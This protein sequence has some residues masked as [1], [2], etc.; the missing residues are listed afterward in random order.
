MLGICGKMRLLT[1]RLSGCRLIA[2]LAFSW[3][4]EKNGAKVLLVKAAKLLDQQGLDE[5]ASG[6]SGACN[7][8]CLDHSW[9]RENCT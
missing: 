8:H 7:C 5:I 3:P 4:M 2:S 6:V 9:E 1:D